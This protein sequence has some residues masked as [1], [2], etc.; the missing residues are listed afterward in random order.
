LEVRVG[1]LK[2]SA[3]DSE[4]GRGLLGAVQ[5]EVDSL[6]VEVVDASVTYS[7]SLFASCAADQSSP[8]PTLAIVVNVSCNSLRVLLLPRAL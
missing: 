4:V 3:Q 5:R 8:K 6:G 1:A 7:D 2:E